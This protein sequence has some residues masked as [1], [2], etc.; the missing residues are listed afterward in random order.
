ALRASKR[1]RDVVEALWPKV[2][3]VDVVFHLLSD[4]ETL[5]AAAGSTL[6]SREQELLAWRRH[7]ARSRAPWTPADLVLVD[8]ASGAV[9]RPPAYAHVV[10]DE[11]QDLSP[12]E[13]RAIGRRCGRSATVLGD[14]AQATTAWA[15]TSWSDALRHLGLRQARMETLHR[16]FRI[17]ASVLKMANRLLPSIAPT[18][19]PAVAV[20]DAPDALALVRAPDGDVAGTVVGQVAA[21]L[22]RPGS[23]GVI[24]PPTQH[25]PVAQALS[26]SG[27]EWGSVGEMAAGRRVTLLG[28]TEAKGLEF[29]VVVLVEP[30]ALVGSAQPAA[31]QLLYIA[32]TRAVLRLVVVHSGPLPDQLVRG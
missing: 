21:S 11:A 19:A 18:L 23:I 14:L 26:R 17:Q 22:E 25:G 27:T 1:A 32:V 9:A 6:S 10:V 2:D 7:P 13:L 5:A 4:P 3:P 31:L 16:A 28:A 8:E 20:R 12:M 24:V 29:D 15:S 30:E